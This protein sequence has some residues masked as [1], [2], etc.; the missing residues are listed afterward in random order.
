MGFIGKALERLH[1]SKPKPR[2]LLDVSGLIATY[3]SLPEGTHFRGSCIRNGAKRSVKRFS[4]YK[5][6]GVL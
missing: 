1:L 5:K 4:D 6:G 3:S 2:K